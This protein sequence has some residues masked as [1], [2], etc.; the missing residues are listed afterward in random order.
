MRGLLLLSAFGVLSSL[1]ASAAAQNTS[2]NRQAC[3]LSEPTYSLAQQVAGCTAVINAGTATTAVLADALYYRGNAY[4]GQKQYTRAIADYSQAIRL[5]P[6]DAGAFYNRGRAYRSQKQYAKAI[7]DF[8]QVIRL[9]PDYAWTFDDRGITYFL[10]GKYSRAIADF[11]EAI[12]LDS[13]KPQF[14]YDRGVAELRLGLSAKGHAD[15]ARAIK[16][17]PKVAAEAAEYGV[18]P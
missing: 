16:A 18:K 17:N 15:I 6:D 11:D 14:Y 10:W 5:K 7:A 12:R 4:K 13:N 2:Q 1:A 8:D 9:G 3:F